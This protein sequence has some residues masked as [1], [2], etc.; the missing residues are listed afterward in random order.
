MKDLR[1]LVDGD[2][3]PAERALLEAARADQPAD[4]AA[5]MRT[6]A[7]LAAVAG[8][9]AVATGAAKAGAL[10]GAT[11][12]LSP[13]IVKWLLVLALGAALGVGAIAYVRGGRA[14]AGSQGVRGPVAMAGAETEGVAPPPPRP[15]DPPPS[16]P[17]L[18]APVAAPLLANAPALAAPSA[19]QVAAP[20]AAA[21]V[22][23]PAPVAAPA[24][25]RAP[26]PAAPRAPAR[27]DDFAAPPSPR[28]AETA[29]LPLPTPLAA[30]ALRGTTPGPLDGRPPP[31]TTPP[32]GTAL[33]S[34]VA[35]LDLART[36]LAG[37]DPK[38]AL[39]ALGNYDRAFPRGAL[40]Q[41]ATL[42]RIDALLQAGD[43]AGA[44]ALADAFLRADPR[45]PYAKRVRDMLGH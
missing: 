38:S 2:A 24:L 32:P 25:A 19:A 26:A 41:E 12:L 5:R 33:S 42:M 9:G 22:A 44:V 8:A 36:A 13:S 11:K 35:L 30:P 23:A 28:G 4:D 14:P 40:A 21:Q 34:E 18:A 31:N 45:G 16:A 39:A 6:L 15:E 7:A 10:G 3:S 37:H 1:R 27:A 20:S 17:A 43:R 29:P